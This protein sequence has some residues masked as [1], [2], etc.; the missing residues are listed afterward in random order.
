MNNKEYK[1]ENKEINHVIINSANI[2]NYQNLIEE[3][4]D[5]GYDMEEILEYAEFM[6]ISDDSPDE[7]PDI[8]IES[9]NK[10]NRQT[11]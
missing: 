3:L 1:D 8:I 6:G 7:P 11:N 2:R 9:S 4:L 5:K 10:F